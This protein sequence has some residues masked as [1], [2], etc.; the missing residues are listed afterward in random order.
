MKP[1]WI[2]GG[3][4]GLLFAML[5]AIRIGLFRK[6]SPPPSTL[7][8]AGS[9]AAVEKDVWKNVLQNGRKIGFSNSVWV[10]TEGGYRTRETLNLR[11]N[12]MGMVQDLTVQT[13][14]RLHP[15]FTLAAFD[16]RINSGRFQFTAR[17]SVS[18]NALA[19]STKTAGDTE[20]ITMPITE[21]IYLPSGMIQ[22][23][24]ASRLA[25]GETRTF[26]LFDPVTMGKAPVEIK[27]FGMET[28]HLQGTPHRARKVSLTFKGTSQYAWFDETGDVL[29]ESSLL[30]IAM[31]RTSREDALF[32]LPVESSQD[33]TTVASIAANMDIENPSVLEKITVRL[34]GVNI[35]HRFLTG[36]RQVYKDG[37]LTVQK[38]SVSDL[39]ARS[40]GEKIDSQYLDPA[41]F[42]QSDHAEIRALAATITAEAKSPLS[43]AIKLVSWMQDNIQKR[44]VLSLPDALTTLKNKAGDCNEHAVL[45]AALARS[46]GIPAKLEAGLVYMNGRFYYHAWNLL[47]LG[48]WITVDA[49]LGQIPA[50][51]THMRFSGGAH[52]LPIDL[53]GIIGNINVTIIGLD[54]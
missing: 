50:D 21:P 38:E 48:R 36:G 43:K 24:A 28:I 16:I 32:G 37:I 42:I 7:H 40:R 54:Q 52:A 45:L 4:F 2:G 11:I 18:D 25:P 6:P 20:T 39:V 46:V 53:L 41:P 26:P 30:G 27:A 35:D 47:F 14:G 22:A 29:K 23:A 3:L 15:D 51:V 34:E 44:P 13:N 9:S 33:L 8:L 17:G 31:E 19:I 12:M 1:F 10:K 49:T 5:F